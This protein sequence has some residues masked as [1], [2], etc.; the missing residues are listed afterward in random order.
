MNIRNGLKPLAVVFLAFTLIGCSSISQ[1]DFDTLEQVQA[2]QSGQIGL[3]RAAEI[4]RQKANGI[5]V[6]IT[7]HSVS[8]G[9]YYAVKLVESEAINYIAIDAANGSVLTVERKRQQARWLK[10]RN[11]STLRQIKYA[12]VSLDDAIA[13]AEAITG[14]K[15]VEVMVDDQR[16]PQAYEVRSIRLG[17]L[18]TTR[19][20]FRDE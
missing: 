7:F 11:R 10:R 13:N 2:A 3:V 6:E 17:V 19:I 1:D 5:P 8:V 9:A 20:A 14:G 15:A 12:Q 4:A 16:Y 18:V